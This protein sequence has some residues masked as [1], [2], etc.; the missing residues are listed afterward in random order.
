MWGK[1]KEKP[2]EIESSVIKNLQVKKLKKRTPTIEG[3]VSVWNNTMDADVVIDFGA[4]EKCDVLF[5]N[6]QTDIEQKIIW[7]QTH[8]IEICNAL[9]ND[10]TML[11][12]VEE[13]VSQLERAEDEESECYIS[14]DGDK[15]YLPVTEDA[16][17]ESLQVDCIKMDARKGIDFLTIHALLSFHPD[18]FMGHGL[19]IM[20]H[21]DETIEDCGLFG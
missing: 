6:C 13:W 15:I 7:L 10:G 17:L 5:L 2:L 3:E 8:K 11:P 21:E 4:E 16:F 1:K 18:Y 12:Y 9:I 20:I 14:L 19:E